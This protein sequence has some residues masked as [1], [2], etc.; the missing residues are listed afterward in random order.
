MFH[1]IQLTMQ[2]G[3]NSKEKSQKGGNPLE[4][5]V[6]IEMKETKDGCTLTISR[7][8]RGDIYFGKKDEQ[9]NLTFNSVAMPVEVSLVARNPLANNDEKVDSVFVLEISDKFM[10]VCEIGIIVFGRGEGRTTKLVTNYLFKTSYGLDENNELHA[11]SQIPKVML[12]AMREVAIAESG[13]KKMEYDNAIDKFYSGTK[14]V[15]KDEK[16]LP[17]WIGTVRILNVDL[18]RGSITG[19]TKDRKIAYITLKM[20]E[21]PEEAIFQAPSVKFMRV[22]GLKKTGMEGFDLIAKGAQLPKKKETKPNSEKKESKPKADA[23][24]EPGKK[25]AAKKPAVKK[26]ASKKPA[27]EKKTAEAKA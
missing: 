13:S 7:G 18:L 22:F 9:K 19:V 23:K 4:L 26:A 5:D 8:G 21:S 14:P 11:S 20:F 3:N 6:N 12:R 16:G 27:A 25:A 17:K 1:T 15:P 2:R 10:S 24:K